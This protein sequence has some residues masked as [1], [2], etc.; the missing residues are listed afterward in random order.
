MHLTIFLL[1]FFAPGLALRAESLEVP[2]PLSAVLP[3]DEELTEVDPTELA[4]DSHVLL[5][6]S[7]PQD[8]P[9]AESRLATANLIRAP[10][11]LD[12]TS[13]SQL[14]TEILLLRGNDNFF[15]NLH[16]PLLW[17]TLEAVTTKDQFREFLELL[18]VWRMEG[19]FIDWRIGTK[20][21]GQS[22]LLGPLVSAS[23]PRFS[24]FRLLTL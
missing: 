4:Q 8:H 3:P 21:V 19:G 24:P 13:F 15:Q 17:H 1:A 5:P 12:R 2:T 22:P 20:I 7:I 10:D 9:Y 14:S 23:H 18:K 11:Q 16:S 6:S